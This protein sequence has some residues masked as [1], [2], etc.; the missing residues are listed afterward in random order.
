MITS[1]MLH[2]ATVNRGAADRAKRVVIA[3][4]GISQAR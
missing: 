4:F 1:S 2:P 3:I